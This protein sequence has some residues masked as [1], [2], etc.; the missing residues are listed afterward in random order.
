MSESY[1][2]QAAGS[3]QP[4]H[5]RVDTQSL[6]D[7]GT[8][9][10]E[11]V[12]TLEFTGQKADQTAIAAATRLPPGQLEPLLADLTSRGLLTSTGIGDSR[13]YQPARRDWSAQPAEG[14]GPPIG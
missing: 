12:A 1:D 10:Y 13:V 6:T 4:D 2:P 9:V 14:T 3:A 8:D 7:A 5:P 11:T